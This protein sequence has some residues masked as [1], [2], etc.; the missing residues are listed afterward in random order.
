MKSGEKGA[1]V[2]YGGDWCVCLRYFEVEFY[3]IFI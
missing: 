1:T 3:I 2:G